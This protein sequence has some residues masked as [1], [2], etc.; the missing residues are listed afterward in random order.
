MNLTRHLCI[1]FLA[2]LI[3]VSTSFGVA[4][5]SSGPAPQS[6]TPTP[7]TSAPAAASLPVRE[8]TPVPALQFPLN[9]LTL[10]SVQLLASWGD[11]AIRE[12]AWS[13]AGDLLAAATDLG[14]YLYRPATLDRVRF[15][16]SGTPVEA[17]AFSP[18]GA[19]LAVA[20]KGV[21]LY[22]TQTGTAAW[23]QDLAQPASGAAFDFQKNALAVLVRDG[24]ELY[25]KRWTLAD[26]KEQPDV[27]IHELY[28]Q[29]LALSPDARLIVDSAK[30]LISNLMRI[31]SADSGEKLF[32]KSYNMS[33]EF[34]A[35]QF[36]PDG[37]ELAALTSLA[38]PQTDLTVW[39][40]QKFRVLGQIR[41]PK[42]PDS[43]AISADNTLLAVTF[44][45]EAQVWS[46]KNYQKKLSL[47]SENQFTSAGSAFS[48]DGSQLAAGA[49]EVWDL[50][51]KTRLDYHDHALRWNYAI[52]PDGQSIALAAGPG[53]QIRRLANADVQET[54]PVTG[55]KITNLEYS[56]DG[57]RLSAATDAGKVYLWN[58]QTW[59]AVA[60]LKG[61][62][63]SAFSLSF[64]PD[65]ALLVVSF[66]NGAI[67]QWDAVTGKLAR[68]WTS[69]DQKQAAIGFSPDGS[70]V[71]VNQK[72]LNFW[73]MPEK[74]LLRSFKGA[75]E[76]NP[77]LSFSG[78]GAT[79]VLLTGATQLFETQSGMGK[80]C[81]TAEEEVPVSA[82][83]T[84][85]GGFLAV[86][87]AG[88]KIHLM[89]AASCQVLY[90]L[91]NTLPANLKLAPDMATLLS[92]S[93]GVLR[94]WGVANHR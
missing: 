35:L 18:D 58:T 9:P 71:E 15:Y 88:G 84:P 28:G 49:L 10:S 8:G 11:G 59:E 23:T 69:T 77:V 93:G 56:A 17:V 85:D 57:K 66:R 43:T 76:F 51:G 81:L 82:L 2:L 29:Q 92:A 53:I 46:L 91:E 38:L 52:S 37:K 70:L 6:P 19:L 83:L 5:A 75:P 26:G 25:L 94:I 45:Q 55:G 22:D 48:P 72:D 54:L 89:S 78:D 40:M 39:D 87:V 1:G 13:P 31:W 32:E 60:E 61:S 27:Q 7:A 64:S 3:S 65:S 30:G 20:A 34:Q 44:S 24:E 4:R 62:A 80:K 67:Q 36:S 90:T 86:S 41:L 50:A 12:V 68:T 14:T 21:T 47:P 74:K 16:P 42:R 33:V 79:L 73:K 63:G